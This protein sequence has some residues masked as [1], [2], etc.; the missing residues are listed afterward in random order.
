MNTNDLNRLNTRRQ[1]DDA[2][3]LMP[4][5]LAAQIPL[6]YATEEQGDAATVYVKYFTPGS[7][8]TWYLTEYDPDE[9]LCFGLVI[10]LD[11]ELGY[12]SLDE[13]RNARGPHGLRVE[14]DLYFKATPLA[15]IRSGKAR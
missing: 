15:D 11:T 1:S 10:G 2:H 14:R 5:D 7:S 13:L 12:F 8:W 3:D 6:L 9:H 4:A